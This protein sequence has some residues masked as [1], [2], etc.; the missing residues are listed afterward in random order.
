[1][2]KKKAEVDRIAAENQK[3]EEDRI[4]KEAEA[5]R[6]AQIEEVKKAK[7]AEEQRVTQIEED[8]KAKLAEDQRL[9]QAEQDRIKKEAEAQRLAQIE[10]EKQQKEVEIKQKAAELKKKEEAMRLAAEEIKRQDA[11]LA[12]ITN[13][14]LHQESAE[15]TKAYVKLG[16]GT[17]ILCAGIW[18]V[19]F[20]ILKSF[21]ICWNVRE[22]WRATL[23]PEERVIEVEGT[24]ASPIE[25]KLLAGGMALVLAAVASLVLPIAWLPAIFWLFSPFLFAAG[26]IFLH[27]L[28][29]AK[30]SLSAAGLKSI[31]RIGWFTILYALLGISAGAASL[32]V[33]AFGE[34]EP[35]FMR[36]G[37]NSTDIAV[38]AIY[39]AVSQLADSEVSIPSASSLTPPEQQYV[40]EIANLLM[41]KNRLWLILQLKTERANTAGEFSKVLNSAADRVNYWRAKVAS[42]PLAHGDSIDTYAESLH[43][44]HE[45]GRRMADAAGVKPETE[46]RTISFKSAFSS[47]LEKFGSDAEVKQ[48]MEQFLKAINPESDPENRNSVNASEKV[49]AAPFD[50]NHPV[51]TEPGPAT[52][53]GTPTD[54]QTLNITGNLPRYSHPKANQADGQ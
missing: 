41:A 10:A 5:R 42:I 27:K 11:E 4:K 53:A 9:A 21:D 39:S 23:P 3:Q 52:E 12:A 34:K 44:V 48:A 19:V 13:K 7:L 24:R 30:R 36:S 1:M 14:I 22:R 50:P 8:K 43:K 29:S 33:L 51:W 31:F 38:P 47:A 20:A 6:L 35:A 54:M 16:I 18:A 45:I 49:D 37:W 15:R 26:I 32:V 28:S 25:R 40:Q 17:L 46:A 2:H